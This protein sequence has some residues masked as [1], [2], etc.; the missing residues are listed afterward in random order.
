MQSIG[1]D[2]APS[3]SSTPGRGLSGNG[4]SDSGP[5]RPTPRG[6]AGAGAG[7]AGGLPQEFLHDPSKYPMPH[8]PFLKTGWVVVCVGGGLPGW[9][10]AQPQSLS[11]VWWKEI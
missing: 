5:E 9:V 3:G 2:A 10:C 7:V 8:I 11:N 6:V 1:S 4:G